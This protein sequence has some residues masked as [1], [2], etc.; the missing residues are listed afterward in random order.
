MCKRG[1]DIYQTTNIALSVTFEF[2]YK[3][4]ACIKLTLQNKC[5][6]E[7]ILLNSE[8]LYELQLLVRVSLHNVYDVIQSKLNCVTVHVFE[9][10]VCKWLLLIENIMFTMI[11]LFLFIK[12][13]AYFH[14]V[15]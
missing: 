2:Y 15:Y 13:F 7:S 6:D 4:I 12:F 3:N 14:L 11:F 1:N 10:K 9:S 5:D 8:M